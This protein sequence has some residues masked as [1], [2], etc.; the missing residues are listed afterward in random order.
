[1]NN[2]S[3]LGN[4]SINLNISGFKDDSMFSETD[5]IH[6]SNNFLIKS[7]SNKSIEIDS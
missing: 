1:M 7:I 3:L 2:N 4:N 5:E 6:E